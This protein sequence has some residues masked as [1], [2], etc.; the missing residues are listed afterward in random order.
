MEI[1][2]TL[3]ERGYPSEY[4]QA[5]IR[6]RRAYRIVDWEHIL[7]ADRLEAVPPLPHRSALAG[8]SEEDVWQNLLR[9]F[10]WLYCQ[11]EQKMRHKF[12]PVFGYFEL[13][14]LILCLRNKGGRND[15]KVHD[16][17]ADSL[18]AGKVQ[19]VLKA[20][21]D[22]PHVIDAVAGVLSAGAMKFGRLGKMFREQGFFGF[23]QGLTNL[24]LEE[25]INGRLHPL[26]REFISRL[27]D[28]R[29]VITL[30][31]QLRWRIKSPPL[32]IGGGKIRESALSEIAEKNAMEEIT[33]LI[34]RLA[35]EEVEVASV[36]V[37]ERLLLTGITRLVRRR[38]REPAGTGLILD[39]LWRCYVETRNLSLLAY[40]GDDREA[41]RRELVL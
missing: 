4:L 3:Q 5:R 36:G 35:G 22:L 18:L 27:I 28:T 30:Y 9:E 31:K 38:G 6:G 24:Y 19:K 26:I 7:S 20:D 14:T 23:E 29:N 15:R 33:P 8:R 2:R 25:V 16:L 41:V 40:C 1:L 10:V 12:S 11:M 13:R 39:Y 17:L 37:T 32:F 21:E 34:R